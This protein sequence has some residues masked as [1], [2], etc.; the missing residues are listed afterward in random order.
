MPYMN[1]LLNILK[2][3]KFFFKKFLEK[4]KFCQ[5]EFFCIYFLSQVFSYLQYF[6]ILCPHGIVFEISQI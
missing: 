1:I 5:P 6:F 3:L 2:L 4:I